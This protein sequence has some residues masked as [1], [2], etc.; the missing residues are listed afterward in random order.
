MKINKGITLIALVITII[1]LLIL[2]GVSISLVL[3]ENGV[4]NK[5]KDSV[6]KNRFASAKE[7]IEFVLASINTE[8][9]GTVQLNNNGLSIEDWATVGMLRE[10][11]N[12][13][14]YE[15]RLEGNQ[16]N[17]RKISEELS[18]E[19]Y[20]SNL[21]SDK[22]VFTIKPEKLYLSLIGGEEKSISQ[23]QVVYATSEEV[24]KSG[25]IFENTTGNNGNFTGKIMWDGIYNPEHG[26]QSH[27]SKLNKELV[28]PDYIDNILVTSIPENAFG[29][30]GVAREIEG[31]D[32]WYYQYD[33]KSI[34]I[35]S[36]V[37]SI[38]RFAFAKC[39][40]LQSITMLGNITDIGEGVFYDCSKLTDIT[41]QS[42]WGSIP[43]YLFKNCSSLDNIEIPEGITSISVE[44]F[45]GCTSLTNVTIPKSLTS[46]DS[47]AF[48]G[49]TSLTEINYTGKK[50]D[51]ENIDGEIYGITIHC[52]DGDIFVENNQ[53][54]FDPGSQVLMADGKV[55]NIENVQIGDKV[56]SFNEDTKEFLPQRVKTTIIK[57]N[58]DDLVYV[59]LSNGD[60]I[61]MRAYHPLL[62]KEGYKSLR[63]ELAETSIE[64]KEDIP[65]LKVGDE[66]VGY[67]GNV[68]IE[69]IEQREEIENYDTYNLEIEGY[70]N[71]IVNNVVVHN[72]GDPCKTMVINEL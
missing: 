54:C 12:K 65:L 20:K 70:H 39:K 40:N 29:S 46:I 51:W 64:V 35:P 25:L 30:L 28:I 45:S 36:G 60:C 27:S 42:S 31:V 1:V 33:G 4:L 13:N 7:T 37:T 8:F 9:M 34:S 66:L 61:G 53:C 16:S 72:A 5:A 63:P 6:K 15:L 24:R 71:Y 26:V 47:W 67:Y 38:G 62:T 32:Y 57:H 14:E 10:K 44:A 55:K 2:A 69:S 50:S 68:F 3:G 21:P 49:C 23:T 58:S 11:L 19:I 18:I 41:I 48:N 52:S 43:N 56:M 17:N 22:Y 59:K